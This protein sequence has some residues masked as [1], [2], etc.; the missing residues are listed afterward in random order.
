MLGFGV[1]FVICVLK[2][3]ATNHAADVVVIVIVAWLEEYWTILC[4]AFMY[5][6]MLNLLH[7]MR[8]GFYRLNYELCTSWP[9][10]LKV[11][12]IFSC[13]PRTWFL[14]LNVKDH[15]SIPVFFLLTT[16]Q[17]YCLSSLRRDFFFRYRVEHSRECKRRFVMQQL[18]NN[19]F[20]MIF[21]PIHW[22]KLSWCILFT[23]LYVDT[24]T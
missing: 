11:L 2:T 16:T 23:G 18:S 9:Y 1:I 4:I 21:R 5:K 8:F 17:N 15:K 6:R 24:K 3:T 7:C 20:W 10:L 12:A 19:I 13:T 14:N 22:M